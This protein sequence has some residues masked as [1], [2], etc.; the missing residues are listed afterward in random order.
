M[1]E[2][3]TCGHPRSDH[4]QYI[5]NGHDQTRCKSCDPM[6]GIPGGNYAMDHDSYVAAMYRAADH[7]FT[8]EQET[9]QDVL[10]GDCPTEEEMYG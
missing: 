3:C 5:L 8:P 7:G 2:F 9:D 1:S 10:R 6:S 4:Y